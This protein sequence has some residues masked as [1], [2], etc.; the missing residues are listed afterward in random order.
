MYRVLL[1]VD[2]DE[3]RARSQVALLESLPV[4]PED[5][6]VILLHVYEEID[7]PADEAGFAI[8]DDI[9]RS[10]EE[11]QGQ[12]ETIDLVRSR[13][14][15]LGISNELVEHVGEPGESIVAVAADR[16]VD[17][18]ALGMRDRRSAV[19]KALFGSVTQHVIL[20]TDRPVFVDKA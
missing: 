16:D 20:N 10:I 5:I 15:E 3:D 19:G 12:P 11:I 7:A 13:L 9:N 2:I 14:E 1:P 18:I 4:N 6:E 8:M 17:A